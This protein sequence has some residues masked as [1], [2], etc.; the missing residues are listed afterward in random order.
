MQIKKLIKNYCSWLAGE[1]SVQGNVL[2][3]PYLDRHNDHIQ[4]YPEKIGSHIRV[5][6]NGE[7]IADLRMSG[8][9]WDDR[10]I[11]AILKRCA[12]NRDGDELYVKFFLEY[13][14]Q[15]HNLILAILKIDSLAGP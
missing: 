9:N 2:T 13:P 11:D 10:E 12:V 8:Y 3:I 7:T 5:S 6:D 1:F 15:L 4:L 14:L